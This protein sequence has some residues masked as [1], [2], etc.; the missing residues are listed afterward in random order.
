MRLHGCVV[1][2]RTQFLSRPR[3]VKPV[4]GENRVQGIN[5]DAGECLDVIRGHPDGNFY[6]RTPVMTTLPHSSSGTTLGG[7]WT[8]SSNTLYGLLFF[9]LSMGNGG[10]GLHREGGWLLL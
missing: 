9:V 8:H 4:H 2:A 3:T 1:S 7:A 10:P 5:A 6:H